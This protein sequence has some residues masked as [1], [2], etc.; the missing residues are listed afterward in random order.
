MTTFLN[1]PVNPNTL[2]ILY[3]CEYTYNP[4][5]I[6]V[7]REIQF[8]SPSLALEAYSNIPNPES[9]LALGNTQTELFKELDSLHN[10]LNNPKWVKELAEYL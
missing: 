7:L 6:K 8:E 4:A 1:Q 10:N 2:G 5:S 3:L 9:Q